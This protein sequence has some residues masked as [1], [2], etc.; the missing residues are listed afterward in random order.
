LQASWQLTSFLRPQDY[1]NKPTNYSAIRYDILCQLFNLP[2]GFAAFT[3]S[4][5]PLLVVCGSEVDLCTLQ[6]AVDGEAGGHICCIGANWGKRLLQIDLRK[7]Q[8]CEEGARFGLGTA[9]VE[10]NSIPL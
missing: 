9:G 6:A 2:A 10:I 1:H 8:S 7:G 5:D 3:M 4:L